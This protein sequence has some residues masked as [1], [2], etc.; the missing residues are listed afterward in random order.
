MV[1]TSRI[2]FYFLEGLFSVFFSLLSLRKR[3]VQRGCTG[4]ALFD[5]EYA[6]YLLT[7]M[8][9]RYLPIK[10]ECNTCRDGDNITDTAYC[11]DMYGSL[12]LF[13]WVKGVIRQCPFFTT[14]LLA[15]ELNTSVNYVALTLA[16]ARGFNKKP[17][18]NLV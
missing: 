12:A 5:D 18:Q 13:A 6:R 7:D 1:T 9:S 10:L 16:C 2:K 3:N 17:I 11:G 14:M 8:P 15:F 4:A